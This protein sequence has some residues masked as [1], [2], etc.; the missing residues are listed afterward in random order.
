LSYDLA[1]TSMQIGVQRTIEYVQKAVTEI[2]AL[3]MYL[4]R[5]GKRNLDTWFASVAEAIE[6]QRQV[7][8]A[9]F[10]MEKF[11]PLVEVNLPYREDWVK[12]ARFTIKEKLTDASDKEVIQNY[13]E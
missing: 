3:N 5:M 7:R 11:F 9:Y 6:S 2:D 8:I 13:I 10:M 1:G 4:G 12:F